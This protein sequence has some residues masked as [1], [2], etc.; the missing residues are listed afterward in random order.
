MTLI[1]LPAKQ[2]MGILG[3]YRESWIF[4]GRTLTTTF[5]DFSR[6]V[7][8]QRFTII[9]NPVLVVIFTHSASISAILPLNKLVSPM[10]SATKTVW[11]LS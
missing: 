3:G 2:F 4:S 11:G 6:G 8:S 9:V 10:K 5:W 7:C 1:N